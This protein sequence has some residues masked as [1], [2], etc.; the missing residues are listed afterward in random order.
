MYQQSQSYEVR[1]LSYRVKQIKMF[2]FWAILDPF[3]PLHDHKNLNLQK[4]KKYP[5]IILSI[6][7]SEDH[8]IY[9]S[10]D[11]KC[12]EQMR[13]KNEKNAQ[14]YHFTLVYHKI[15]SNDVRVLRYKVRQTE[16]FVNLG[17]FSPFYP[18]NNLK[19]QNF[20]TI[21]KLL[22]DIIIFKWKSHD[23]WFL[24]YGAW[25]TEFFDI[26]G[27]FLPFYPTNNPKNWHFEKMKKSS[28]DIIIV[29]KC[30]KNNDH[31]LYCSWDMARDRCNL[32]FFLGC[33]LPFYSPPALVFLNLDIF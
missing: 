31:I 1:F 26:A 13:W 27:F 18:T 21:K 8:M 4:S 29:H 19:N 7:M 2:V 12:D 17:Y 14:R 32:F 30:A 15:W 3:T 23:M 33:F 9:G 20:K 28:G 16:V 24:R 5:Q 25:Q 10:W 11:I 22:G 6:I